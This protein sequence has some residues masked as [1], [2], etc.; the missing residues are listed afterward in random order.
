M[1][2]I[3]MVVCFAIWAYLWFRFV[4]SMKVKE[5]TKNDRNRFDSDMD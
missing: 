1:K 3:I 2:E 5:S 4:R